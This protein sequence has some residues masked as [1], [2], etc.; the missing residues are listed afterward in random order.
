MLQRSCSRRMYHRRLAEHNAL[1]PFWHVGSWDDLARIS[2]RLPIQ[3]LM[4]PGG[5][6]LR[7]VFYVAGLV[8]DSI[9]ERQCTLELIELCQKTSGR[10]TVCIAGQLRGF[11]SK[12][13]WRE[14]WQQWYGSALANA[15]HKGSCSITAC[16]ACLLADCYISNMWTIS[17]RKDASNHSDVLMAYPNCINKYIIFFNCVKLFDF[18]W[19]VWLEPLINLQ[20][21]SNYAPSPRS[22]KGPAQ[23]PRK[24]CVDYRW[25]T[26]N[27]V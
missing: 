12:W 14:F 3:W 23:Y 11:W 10:Q 22:Q 17:N 24:G 2:S 25:F 27:W 6:Y 13:V 19:F 16:G 5:W 1:T 15:G 20:N 26:R 18:N 7:N 9:L 21:A 8:T 4:K